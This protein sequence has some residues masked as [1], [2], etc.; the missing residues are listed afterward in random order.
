MS[1]NNKGGVD[2]S[3]NGLGNKVT[4]MEPKIEQ[5]GQDM[6]TAMSAVY[7]MQAKY[8]YTM[9][10][11]LDKMEGISSVNE[12]DFSDEDLQ[13]KFTQ[14]VPGY[15]FRKEDF[16]LVKINSM[17]KGWKLNKE[18]SEAEGQYVFQHLTD[19]E[20][21]SSVEAPQ[22]AWTALRANIRVPQ[23]KIITI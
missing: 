17:F 20:F 19:G 14:V 7:E 13:T 6:F 15:A 10:Y 21:R 11:I 5:L 9:K 1:K 2:F 4:A 23:S 16:T 3:L 22:E 18:M 12:I 8:D